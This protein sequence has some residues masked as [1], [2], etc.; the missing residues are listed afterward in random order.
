VQA[1]I[2]TFSKPGDLVCDPFGG[3]G[4]TAVEAIVCRRK[5]IHVD[6]LPLANFIT[7][8]TVVAPVKI[9][10]LSRAFGQVKKACSQQILKLYARTEDDIEEMN[11][12]FWYPKDVPLPSNAD[13]R[14]VHELFTRRSLIALSILRHHIMKL[15]DPTLRDLLLFAFSGTLAKVNRTFVSAEGRAESRGGATIFSVYR[16]YVPPDPVELNV[17]EQFDMRFQKLLKAKQETNDAIGDFYRPGKTLKIIRGSATDLRKHIK[18]GSVDYIYTDPPYGAH[19]AY[20]DLGVMWDAWLGFKVAKKDKELEVIE[21]GD[22][23]KSKEEYTSLL[24][25]SIREMFR[26]LKYD[27]WLSI[28]FTHKDPAYW[29]AI[30][31][32]CQVAGFEYI[33]TAVQPV[34]VVWS[35]HKKKNPLRVLAGELV[36]NFRKVRNPK[37]IA[38]TKIGTSTVQLIKDIAELTIVKHGSASTEEIYNN[39]I[40]ML[41]EAGKLGE[42]RQE[43]SDITPL[44]K[45]E[46]DFGQADGRWHTRPNTKIGNFVPLPARIRFYVTDYLKKMERLDQRATFDEIVFNVMP[47]LINGEQPTNQT[48]LAILQRIAHSP[49]GK[50][51]VLGTKDNQLSMDFGFPMH[52]ANIPAL[53]T[54]KGD[55]SHTEIVYRLAKLGIAA[56][57]LVHIGKKEQTAEWQGEKLAALSLNVF[58]APSRTSEFSLKKIE[59]IDCVFFDTKGTPVYAFEVE[60][61]TPITTALE[62]FM[63]LLKI[64]PDI[65]SRLVIITPRTRQHKLTEVLSKSH[66][67][68]HPLFMENKIVYLY[69]DEFLRVYDSQKGKLPSNVQLINLL[70]KA[71]TSPRI[72]KQPSLL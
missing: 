24:E 21:G 61:T 46:F 71:S 36:L 6:I 45:E 44:L 47:N 53:P 65:A 3:S 42:I 51:W 62:R 41:L 14:F 4:V 50:H 30:V 34:S 39:L 49:D 70:D 60:G 23:Q 19:I 12:P 56:G 11:I 32:S 55:V 22:L 52:A 2:K 57:L 20:L 25:Q 29:D 63:E 72:Q 16:Y 7:K 18:S 27:R 31:K 58:P 26:I 28:V 37:T 38:I 10:A 66:F 17:W 5:A 54:P 67:I 69:Y 8:N 48:I 68:G 33:N 1:Y 64:N 40:P 9:E 15:S 59:Q 43:I 35:M 13:V